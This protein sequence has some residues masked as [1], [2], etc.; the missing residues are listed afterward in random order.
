MGLNPPSCVEYNANNTKIWIFIAI[1]SVLATLG[2]FAFIMTM[3][4]SG[5]IRAL[6]R[7]SKQHDE[8]INKTNNQ[9]NSKNDISNTNMKRGDQGP[10]GVRGP[11]GATGGVH[12]GAGPLMCIGQKKVITPTFGIKEPSIIYLDNK[13][14]NPIQYWTMQ[15]NP[16]STVTII[17][18]YTGNCITTNNIGDVF[19]DVCGVP[20]TPDQRFNWLPNMQLSSA[21]QQNQCISVEDFARNPS[22]S[23]NNYDLNDMSSKQGSNN[24]TVTKLQLKSCSPSGDLNKAWWIGN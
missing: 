12:S 19:S 18:K 20:P 1:A 14:Y 23:N 11:Q 16:D 9:I 15:N 2:F 5:Q 7:N 13:Q 6:Q 10:P 24:G 3:T 4:K 22:N 17:N 8:T 21:S